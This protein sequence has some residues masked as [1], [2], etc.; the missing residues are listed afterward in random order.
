VRRAR[1]CLALA[2]A[3][4]ATACGEEGGEASVARAAEPTAEPAWNPAVRRPPWT[5][6][7]EKTGP[8]CAIFRIDGGERKTKVEDA[9]C[10]IDMEVGERLRLAGKTCLREG[11]GPAREVPVTCPDALTNAEIAFIE[12]KQRKGELPATSSAKPTP[13]APSLPRPSSA[14]APAPSPAPAA[15]P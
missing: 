6:V 4:G 13:S 15:S 3:C 12:E 11:G 14:P 10:P 8:R 5:F 1:A 2:L 9:A 7:F